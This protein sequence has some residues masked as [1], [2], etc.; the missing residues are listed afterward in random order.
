M[1]SPRTGAEVAMENY[2]ITRHQRQHGREPTRLPGFGPLLIEGVLP[3]G[4]PLAD[5]AAELRAKRVARERARRG[6]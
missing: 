3:P 1:T 2:A 4:H 6:L 5:S